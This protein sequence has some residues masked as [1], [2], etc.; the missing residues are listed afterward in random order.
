MCMNY[1]CQ[2]CDTATY[3]PAISQRSSCGHHVRTAASPLDKSLPKAGHHF[4]PCIGCSN[5]HGWPSA[6]RWITHWG[7]LTGSR[8]R[9]S[10]K[11]VTT[12]TSWRGSCVP[13]QRRRPASSSSGMAP[14]SSGCSLQNVLYAD[15]LVTY[16]T[17]SAPPSSCNWFQYGGLERSYGRSLSTTAT[18]LCDV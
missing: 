3:Q 2:S 18:C 11:S 1:I 10:M 9:R 17:C 12:S 16:P 8:A 13:K 14:P 6:D 5:D 7:A 15:Q 4:T